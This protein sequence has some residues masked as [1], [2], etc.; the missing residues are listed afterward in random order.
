[1]TVPAA[2][3]HAELLP[4]PVAEGKVVRVMESRH[5]QV[6][7][8]KGCVRAQR[9]FGCLVM[10]R[11]GDRVALVETREGNRYILAVLERPGATDLELALP[12]ETHLTTGNHG[13]RISAGTR[14]DLA[15]G[16]RLVLDAQETEIRSSRLRMLTREVQ[17]VGEKLKALLHEGRWIGRLAEV[18]TDHFRMATRTSERDIETLERVRSRHMEIRARETLQLKGENVLAG[19]DKLIRLDGD[20]IHLG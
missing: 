12:G 10:P 3:P 18:F 2:T 1:M 20:Q 5:F 17:V 14:L 15:G 19:A 9:A 8:P 13:L 11:A 4:P 6:E 7:T 16:D